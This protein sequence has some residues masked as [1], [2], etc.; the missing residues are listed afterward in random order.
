MKEKI[1]DLIY[2]ARSLCEALTDRNDIIDHDEELRDCLE[3]LET[4]LNVIGVLEDEDG[5]GDIDE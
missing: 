2:S 5:D 4:A 1:T 3:D